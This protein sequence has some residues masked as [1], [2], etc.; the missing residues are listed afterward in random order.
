M[1]AAAGWQGVCVRVLWDADRSL[2]DQILASD[3]W[4]QPYREEVAHIVGG[5]RG[6]GPVPRAPFAMIGEAAVAARRA[7]LTDMLL[8]DPDG[9]TARATTIEG[10][11]ARAESPARVAA[12]DA[13]CAC[14]FTGAVF[15][16]E[17]PRGAVIFPTP[18]VFRGA[19]FRM[20]AWLNA[21]RF[22]AAADF[23]EALF[24]ADAVF[25][26]SAF[27]SFASFAGARFLGAAEFRKTVFHGRV[28]FSRARFARDIWLRESRFH[29]EAAFVGATFV[30]EA[31]LGACEFAKR[32]RFD[33]A[34]FGG[35]A[36]F[37]RA[38]FSAETSFAGATFDGTAWFRDASFGPAPDFD[39]AR[40][41]GAVKF[42]G[43]RI[44]DALSPRGERFAMLRKSV[45]TLH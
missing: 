35:G 22:L 44:A 16:S 6:D 42:Q 32:C 7:A 2:V 19:R 15:E 34:A 28:D 30:G 14:D 39:R 24:E 8:R 9:W 37:E 12:V 25:E 4:L 45:T 33:K 43:A 11:K 38:V 27:A 3:P 18:A 40:F 26:H 13:I 20:R 23:G 10:I 29:D 41:S 1:L 17:A 5:I 31:G 21:S 36:G